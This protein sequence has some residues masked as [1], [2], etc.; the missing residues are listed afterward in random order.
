MWQ[1]YSEKATCNSNLFTSEINSIS[2]NCY[3][4][5]FKKTWKQII[6]QRK[7]NNSMNSR[8]N[9]TDKN[10]YIRADFQTVLTTIYR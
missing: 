2:K 7:K 3:I 10:F 1:L 9:E 5:A 8:G 6:K 4:L